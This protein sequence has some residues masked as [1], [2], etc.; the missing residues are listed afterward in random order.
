MRAALTL[1][2]SLTTALGFGA[3]GDARQI[4]KIPMSWAVEQVIDSATGDRLCLVVSLGRDVTARL[5]QERGAVTAAWTVIV[6]YENSPGSLRYLRI[7]RS[8]YTSDEP[9]FRGGEAE[10]IVARLSSPDEFVFE[11]A[12]APNQAKRG[13]LYKTGDFA[14]KAAKCEGWIRGTRI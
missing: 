6:G 12:Q 8:V 10:E 14:A 7:G 3:F 2:L 9:S 11:W 1:A 5:T 13:G 4:A